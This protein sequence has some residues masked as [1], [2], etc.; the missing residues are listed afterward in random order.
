MQENR[1]GLRRQLN[2]QAQSFLSRSSGAG[3]S[4]HQGGRKDVSMP[5]IVGALV[6][7]A[8]VAGHLP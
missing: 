6:G 3:P 5:A 4:L 1:D 8:G 2:G 7:S